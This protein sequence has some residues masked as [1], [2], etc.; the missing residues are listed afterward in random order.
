[1]GEKSKLWLVSAALLAGGA[2]LA[3][4]SLVL[5][6]QPCAGNMLT[7]SVFNGYRYEPAFTDGCLVAMDEATSFPLPDQGLTTTGLLG[8][9]A[10]LLLAAAWLVLLPT[11]RLS[12]PGKLVMA[13]PGLVV[14]GVALWSLSAGLTRSGELPGWASLLVEF[15][16]VPAVFVLANSG[17]VGLL[18]AR[19]LVVLLGSTAIGQFHLM[20]DFIVAIGSSDA[21]WDSPPGTGLANIAFVLLMALCTVFLRAVQGSPSRRPIADA[22]APAIT[23]TM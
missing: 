6:W 16:M 21:N 15:A 1:M 18:L 19:Y 3:G 2:G 23:T 17:V 5:F 13:L 9:A 22:T 7:G 11:V 10:A 14:I 4:A 20:A 12:L 8:L